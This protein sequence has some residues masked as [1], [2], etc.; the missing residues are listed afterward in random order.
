MIEFAQQFFIMYID[1][2][3][4]VEISRQ[5]FL[6]TFSTNK[7]NL[8]LIKTFEYIQKF[9]IIIK[10]KFEKKSC[11]FE[12]VIQIRNRVQFRFKF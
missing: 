8:R 1:H 11:C 6:F 9:N 10:H 4:A 3:T 7:L 2:E 5:K 12:C